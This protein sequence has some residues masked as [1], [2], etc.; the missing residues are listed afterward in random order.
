MSYFPYSIFTIK[1]SF[2]LRFPLLTSACL[3]INWYSSARG[4]L[5]ICNATLPMD[6]NQCQLP[7]HS[8]YVVS[9]CYTF[10]ALKVVENRSLYESARRNDAG[11]YEKKKRFLSRKSSFY[12]YF[13]IKVL[14]KLLC[15]LKMCSTDPR[16]A[17]K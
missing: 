15:M 9:P 11:S 10:W 16:R 4:A 12:V 5:G 8:M 6:Y 2:D 7:T 1:A 13:H 17:L 14:C 3:K